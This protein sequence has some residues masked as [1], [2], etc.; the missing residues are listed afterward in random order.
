MADNGWMSTH[1]A[2]S[3]QRLMPHIEDRFKA[4]ILAEPVHWQSF[5][6]RL[7]REW[8]RLF[9]HL[10]RVYGWQYDFFF[11]LE[12]VLCLLAQSW[13]QRPEDL[14]R[15]DEAREADPLWYTSQTVVGGVLYVDLFSDNLAKLHQHIPYFKKLGLSYL[16]LMPLFAVPH[17]DNDGGYAVSDYR[18]VNPDIGTM[19]ELAQ[20]TRELRSEGI[21]LVL[22]LVFNH[23]S[24]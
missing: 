7:N 12:Q 14:K 23:T 4:E 3:L 20:L 10:Q 22:D 16:H 5:L 6:R 21:S 13:F 2:K 8:E 19:Q 15:L 9:Y 1:A 18:A 11:T 24:N 17:G